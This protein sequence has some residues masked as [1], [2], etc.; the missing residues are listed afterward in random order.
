MR[1]CVF[2]DAGVANLQPLTWNRPVFDLRCG[3]SSLLQ[4]HLCLFPAADEYGVWVRPELAALCR[5]AHP[6]LAVN[7]PAGLPARP[8]VAVVLVNGR[9]LPPESLP[10]ALQVPAVGHV[11]GQVAYVALPADAAGAVCPQDLGR[12]L[13]RCQ[14]TLPRLSAGG[15]M[16]DYPWDLVERNA[17]ALEQDYRT[18]CLEGDCVPG[19]DGRAIIG[20]PERCLA[21]ATARVEPMVLIDTTKGPVLID[22]GAQVQAFSRLEGPCHVGAGTHVLAARVRGSSLGPHCRVG[23]EVEASIIHGYSNKAHDGFLGHSYVGEW[24]NIGAGTQSSDLRNDYSEVSV[25]LRGVKVN[26][27]LRKVGCFVGDHTKTSI[28][29]ALNTGTVVGPFGQLLTSGSLPPRA[30]PPFCQFGNGQVQERTDLRQLFATAATVMDRR[31][32]RWTEIDA[33]L[34]FWLYEQTAEQ[35]RQVM[36]ESEQRR[37]RRAM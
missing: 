12:S 19:A 33:D 4:R 7:E 2:E 26:T 36:R 25:V 27:G 3:A 35:R 28:N 18:W 5:L 6:H 13:A 22:D 15:F 23:G 1:I 21:A 9:W 29:A 16:I 20:P 24:V 31:G 34:Y 10:G 30:L 8:P 37:L 32:R 14:Q 11:G 17:A